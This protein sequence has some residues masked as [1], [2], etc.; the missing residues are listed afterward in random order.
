LWSKDGNNHQI[1]FNSLPS[2]IY[3]ATGVPIPLNLTL[4]VGNEPNYVEFSP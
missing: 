2:G 1:N 3:S 4:S